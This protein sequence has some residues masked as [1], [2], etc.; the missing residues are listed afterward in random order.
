MLLFDFSFRDT[1]FDFDFLFSDTI[2][3]TLFRRRRFGRMLRADDGN[4]ALFTPLGHG[5]HLI[6][7]RKMETGRALGQ[8]AS[9]RGPELVA[10]VAGKVPGAFDLLQDLL[11]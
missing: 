5:G 8:A 9:D 10:V 4:V 11:V 7:A 2:S 1:S 6:K 3:E